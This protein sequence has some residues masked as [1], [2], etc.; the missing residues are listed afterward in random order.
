MIVAV[1]VRVSTAEQ[2]L[3][4]QLDST[5]EYATSELGVELSDVETF[6]DKSTGTNTQRSGYQEMMEHVQDGNVDHVVVHEISRLARSLQ[7]LER[8]VTRVTENGAGVHFVRDGLSFGDGKDR[9]MH[10]L[11]MQ[12]LG[13]FAEWQA[14][15]KQMNTK[16]GIAARQ[17]E[18]DY[19][20]G[21]PPLGFEKEN[22][23]LIEGVNYD[24]VC[25]IL[26]MVAKEELSKRKAAEELQSSRTTISRALDRVELY[27][28]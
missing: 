19:H 3:D 25:A 22:G 15:V 10:R 28:V 5:H 13:A 24:Q 1:Y 27:G 16:E 14:R 26:D 18:D 20:H 21:R 12:M 17:A 4:R 9:P 6:R 8:T 7:D 2:N 11:Q 23:R